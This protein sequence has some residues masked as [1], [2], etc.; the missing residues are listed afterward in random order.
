MG[1]MEDPYFTLRRN[2]ITDPNP[3]SATDNGQRT[4]DIERSFAQLGF[5]GLAELSWSLRIG[6][7]FIA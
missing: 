2:I 7:E 5:Y 1:K 4:T 6:G 3:I